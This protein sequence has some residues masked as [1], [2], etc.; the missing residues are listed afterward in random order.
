MHPF[1][2]CGPSDIVHFQALFVPPPSDDDDDGFPF[3]Y[4]PVMGQN[5]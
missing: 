3:L 2:L 4:F 5:V 1:E